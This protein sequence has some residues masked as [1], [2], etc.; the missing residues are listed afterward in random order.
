MSLRP[1]VNWPTGHHPA[2]LTCRQAEPRELRKSAIGACG[3]TTVV[4]SSEDLASNAPGISGLSTRCRSAFQVRDQ[5]WPGSL[6]RQ[7]LPRSPGQDVL[8][9]LMGLRPERRAPEMPPGT[10]SAQQDGPRPGS[11]NY[12]GERNQRGWGSGLEVG[13]QRWDNEEEPTIGPFKPLPG[14]PSENQ[15]PGR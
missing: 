3:L 1:W 9:A 2:P 11:G 10:D 7:P 14:Q 5:G 13:G 4:S 8:S 12:L 15:G 6:A